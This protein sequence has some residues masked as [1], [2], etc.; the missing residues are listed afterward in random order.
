MS[1]TLIDYN[2]A[3]HQIFETST[4][5]WKQTIDVFLTIFLVK[6]HFQERDFQFYRN[7]IWKVYMKQIIEKNIRNLKSR[8]KLQNVIKYRIIRRRNWVP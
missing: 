6:N 2:F 5:A 1:F 7:S 3:G 4:L 8:W